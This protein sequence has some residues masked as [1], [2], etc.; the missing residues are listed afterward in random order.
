MPQPVRPHD[1]TR[2]RQLPARTA[3]P[4]TIR[5]L[6]PRVD[7]G[8]KGA[9]RSSERR[10]LASREALLRRVT[11]EYDE[12]PGLRLSLPQAQRLFGL[13]PDICTRVLNARVAAGLL[14]YEDGAYVRYGVRP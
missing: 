7:P 12:M 14:E 5:T 6:T 10:H 13:R 3:G 2:R 1:I 9:A 11:V 8:E 4:L